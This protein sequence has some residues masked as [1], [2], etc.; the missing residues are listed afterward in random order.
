MENAPQSSQASRG[1][2]AVEDGFM[3]GL[4]KGTCAGLLST[5]SGRTCIDASH[6]SHSADKLLPEEL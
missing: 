1:A 6:V 4:G 3:K 5:R 2:E